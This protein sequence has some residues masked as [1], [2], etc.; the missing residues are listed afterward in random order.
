MSTPP[1]EGRVALVTGA[2]RG[3]GRAIALELARDGA[4]VGVSGRDEAAVALVVDE[5]ATAGLAAQ[6]I[7]ADLV[8]PDEI[9]AAIAACT[10]GLGS[11]DILV[12][13]AGISTEHGLESET[14][15]GWNETLSVNLTA[16]FLLAQ[17]AREALE[18]SH[19]CIVNVGSAL[20]IVAARNA[21]AYSA[22]KA[23]L[24]HLTRQLALELAPSGVRVNCVA[25]GYVAT[26][27]YELGHDA[28]EKERIA[29]LHPMGRVGT[30]EEI[31]RC[32]AFLVSDAASFVTGACL[33][34]DGGLTAQA[35]I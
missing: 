12:N 33:A 23:G 34:V 32:V 4:T 16:P 9:D 5:L 31:A 17:R 18:R 2:T 28:D 14:R 25:P 7:V 30:P 21:T 10:D 8:E 20:G 26:D 3:I 6:G 24:H 27:M 11:L 13:N 35:G 29:R 19:G 22:A 1:F 15:D